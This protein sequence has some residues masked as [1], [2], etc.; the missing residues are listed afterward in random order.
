MATTMQLA[1]ILISASILVVAQY[2]TGQVRTQQVQILPASKIALGDP[3][4]QPTPRCFYDA[5][6][7]FVAID[8]AQV[9]APRKLLRSEPT[10]S[11][12]AVATHIQA[13]KPGSDFW[14]TRCPVIVKSSHV[15][16]QVSLCRPVSII[17]TDGNGSRLRIAGSGSNRVF[18]IENTSLGKIRGRLNAVRNPHGASEVTWLRSSHVTADGRP[19][20]T[21]EFYVYLQDV[22]GYKSYLLE[23]FD[24]SDTQ[25]LAAHLPGPAT[26]CV[27]A[28]TDSS[29]LRGRTP[30]LPK[31]S[32]AARGDARETQTLPTAGVAARNAAQQAQRAA[33]ATGGGESPPL[34]TDTGGGHEPVER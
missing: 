13:L 5:G 16:T 17:D 9:S 25:C 11:G 23:V 1:R 7:Q 32:A 24:K 4:E 20:D 14:V 8:P 33:P 22:K 21:H 29:C 18:K 19:S 27:N 10:A 26:L 31:G 34:Q 3:L 15:V 2:A 12:G 30:A 28:D 6:T